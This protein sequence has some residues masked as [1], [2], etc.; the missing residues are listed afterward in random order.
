MPRP[1]ASAVGSSVEAS[2]FQRKWNFRAQHRRRG[3]TSRARDPSAAWA[4]VCL[5]LGWLLVPLLALHVSTFSSVKWGRG[6]TG[7]SV[8]VLT[9]YIGAWVF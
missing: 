3:Y 6:Q 5:G 9:P 8:A 7:C 4:W 2:G 1:W